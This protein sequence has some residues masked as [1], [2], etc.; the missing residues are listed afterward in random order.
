MYIPPIAQ[1]CQNQP[2]AVFGDGEGL[3]FAGGAAVVGLVV[4]DA[5]L[6][7]GLGLGDAGLAFGLGAGDTGLGFG[8]GEMALGGAACRRDVGQGK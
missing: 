7:F 3:L 1:S 4:G 6:A 5:G 2:E 8:D